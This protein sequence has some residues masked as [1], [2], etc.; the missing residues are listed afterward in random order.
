[1]QLAMSGAAFGFEPSMA[2]DRPEV[3]TVSP[4][5]PGLTPL[6]E[7]ELIGGKL[8]EVRV[9]ASVDAVTDLI[10]YVP[11]DMDGQFLEAFGGQVVIDDATDYPT[12]FKGFISGSLSAV[13]FR[14]AFDG[15]PVAGGDCLFLAEAVF[16][17]SATTGAC[18]SPTD[19]ASTPSGGACFDPDATG[20]VCNPIT[21]EGCAAGTEICDFSG[22]QFLCYPVAGTEVD[23]C[24]PCDTAED[25]FCQVGMTCDNDGASGKCY[26]Y[27]CTDA[28][29]G[30][31]NTCVSY[32]YVTNVGVCVTL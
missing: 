28:D 10:N 29:C 14:E 26:R 2:G 24:E 7:S 3:I 12:Q 25:L 8:A 17:T 1:M 27:C 4:I 21:N 19:V 20:Q 9:F 22:V 16:D 11:G 30:A 15:E 31:G 32:A 23:L 6:G 18:D 5:A 13:V